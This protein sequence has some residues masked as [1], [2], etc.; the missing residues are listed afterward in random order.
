MTTAGGRRQGRA[1]Q[2]GGARRPL[3]YLGTSVVL[4]ALLA[5]DRRPAPAFWS[6]QLISSRLLEFE[7]WTRL[8]AERAPADVFEAARFLVGSAD[9]VELTATVL[10]RALEPFSVRVRTLD[11]L[12]L[13]TASYLASQGMRLE[14]ATYDQRLAE[15]SQAIGLEVVEP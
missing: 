4:A 7:T 3:V 14:V 11:A 10:S 5:E 1:N 13:A 12:H 15:A 8:H 9:L 2:A 6:Q